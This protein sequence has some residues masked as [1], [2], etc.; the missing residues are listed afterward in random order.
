MRGEEQSAESCVEEFTLRPQAAEAWGQVT[1]VVR[2]GLRVLQQ[3]IALGT[4]E[5]W[6][7][8]LLGR[9]SSW[10]CYSGSVVLWKEGE[11][12]ETSALLGEVQEKALS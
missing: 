6:E 4:V 9:W 7:G 3:P 8:S 2:R 12:P 11:T 10:R 5:E 1:F